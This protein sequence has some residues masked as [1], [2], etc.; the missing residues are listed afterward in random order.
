MQQWGFDDVD[1]PNRC[2]RCGSHV[3]STFR[4]TFGDETETVYGCPQC[5]TY[6]ELKD[7]GAAVA[8]GGGEAE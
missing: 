4:R 8:L 3:S 2:R 5:A 6:R 1:E 7:D